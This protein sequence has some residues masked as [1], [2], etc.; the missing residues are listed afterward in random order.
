MDSDTDSCVSFYDVDLYQDGSFLG[1]FSVDYDAEIQA[2]IDEHRAPL[3]DL[4]TAAAEAGRLDL[5]IKIRERKHGAL[6]RDTMAAAGV[7]GHLPTL[8]YLIQEQCPSDSIVGWRTARAGQLECLQYLHEQGV[9]LNA[10]TTAAAAEGGHFACVQYLCEAGFVGKRVLVSAAIAGDL[11]C[12]E[13]LLQL[14]LRCGEA[15]AEAA[16]GGH[17]ACLQRLTD[18]GCRLST[19]AAAAAARN[20]HL[21][22]LQ[23]VV[24]KGCPLTKRAYRAAIE[25]GHIPI[26][27][28]L[29]EQGCWY[30]HKEDLSLCV[31]RKY[32]EC[33]KFLCEQGHVGTWGDA[34]EVCA[35][36]DDLD[37]LKYAIEHGCPA[38]P[39]TMWNAARAGLPLLQYLHEKGCP[40]EEYITLAAIQQ[41]RV[42]CLE[43]LHQHGCPLAPD[44]ANNA[45]MAGSIECLQY[46]HT[47]GGP[48]PST[49]GQVG[50]VE[51]LHYALQHGCTPSLETWQ[52]ALKSDDL[53]MVET[54]YRFDPGALASDC[55]LLYAYSP[56]LKCVRYLHEHCQEPVPEAS[57]HTSPVLKSYI[58]KHSRKTLSGKCLQCSLQSGRFDVLDIDWCSLRENDVTRPYLAARRTIYRAMERAYL[59]PAYS[60]CIRRLRRD[61]AGL[62]EE[63]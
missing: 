2:F 40:L 14:G 62:L 29:R 22:C 46:V 16:A 3:S 47:H 36:M 54:L 59:D 37:F 7:S 58:K 5:L 24:E 33:A 27:Q 38:T 28:Y 34:G 18:Q 10:D 63:L 39:S 17:L 48:L 61:F 30:E 35:L 50:N 55:F 9:D 52:I 45:I 31:R 12:V 19:N 41:N 32:F 53:E 23:W 56:S 42:D 8:Q 4:C 1:S 44:L 60:W 13:Y 11:P 57:V 49:L 43:Y 51:C 15:T 25:G 20:G 21:E 26:L 6:N